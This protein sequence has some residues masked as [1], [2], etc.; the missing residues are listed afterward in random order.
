MLTKKTQMK[1]TLSNADNEKERARQQLISEMTTIVVTKHQRV[2]H[3]NYSMTD[4]IEVTHMLCLT[5]T[6]VDDEGNNCSFR[7]L[8]CHV[9]GIF[10]LKL[11]ANP[12]SYVNR[13]MNRKN[14]RIRSFEDRYFESIFNRKQL[15]N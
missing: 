5:E 11:P 12:Y 8:L 1:E 6:I 10:G 15:Y 4:L 9:F 14:F 7:M 2:L 3:W 13:I